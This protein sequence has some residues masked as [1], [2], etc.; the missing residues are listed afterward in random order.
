MTL[1]AFAAERVR[2]VP[3]ADRCLLQVPS[4]SSKT[5]RTPLLLSIDGTDGRTPDRNNNNNNNKQICIA[6]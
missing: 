5:S 3:T 1:P 2:R 6:P 4:L